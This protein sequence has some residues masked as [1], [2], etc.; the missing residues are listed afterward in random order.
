V[1]E[2]AK[3]ARERGGVCIIFYLFLPKLGWK[4]KRQGERKW[5]SW[6]KKRGSRKRQKPSG[7]RIAAK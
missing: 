5:Q 4:R 7:L 6:R 2:A 1:W 3:R